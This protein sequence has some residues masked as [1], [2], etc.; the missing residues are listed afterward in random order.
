MNTGGKSHKCFRFFVYMILCSFTAGL[1]VGLA[2]QLSVN[3]SIFVCRTQP[4]H[5]E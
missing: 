1:L 3:P 5:P 4:L 2:L